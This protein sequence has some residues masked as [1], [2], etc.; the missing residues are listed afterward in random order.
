MEK[1]ISPVLQIT[2]SKMKPCIMAKS[3]SQ[4]LQQGIL[5]KGGCEFHL[6]VIT[7]G[8]IQETGITDCK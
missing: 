8:D 1:S 2:I 6:Q 5:G 7:K 4:R 3:V